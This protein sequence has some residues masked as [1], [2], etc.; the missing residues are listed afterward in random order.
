MAGCLCVAASR[1]QAVGTLQDAFYC[2][3]EMKRLGIPSDTPVAV[4]QWCVLGDW[5]G[6]P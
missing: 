2:Q 5:E 1:S 6:H 4:Q 3:V